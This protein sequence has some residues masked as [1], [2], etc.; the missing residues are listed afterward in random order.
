[1]VPAMA[2]EK[3]FNV[4]SLSKTAAFKSTFGTYAHYLYVAGHILVP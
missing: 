2:S 4:V 3:T 1:M